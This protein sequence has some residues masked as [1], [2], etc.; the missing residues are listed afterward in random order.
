M[1][2]THRLIRKKFKSSHR[3]FLPHI[4]VNIS[5]Y[6]VFRGI[7]QPSEKALLSRRMRAAQECEVEGAMRKWCVTTAPRMREGRVSLTMLTAT[8]V[9]TMTE[10]FERIG[11]ALYIL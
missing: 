10:R 5:E 8:V 1:L 4:D 3:Q 2:I 7:R 6:L 11:D 9:M